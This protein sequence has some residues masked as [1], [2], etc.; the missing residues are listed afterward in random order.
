MCGYDMII[1][2]G[3]FVCRNSAGHHRGIVS[4]SMPMTTQTQGYDTGSQGYMNK[5]K[6]L[7]DSGRYGEAIQMYNE[8]IKRDLFMAF[9]AYVD[10]LSCL[11]AL[12]R[13][14]DVL[15]VCDFAENVNDGQTHPVYYIQ[16]AK[17]FAIQT[18]RGRDPAKHSIYNTQDEYAY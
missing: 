2:N 14:R 11:L 9:D 17:N 16:Y 18:L 1:E 8:V 15:T 13:Y 4:I 7:K 10:I 5:A 12:R 6:L 3:E